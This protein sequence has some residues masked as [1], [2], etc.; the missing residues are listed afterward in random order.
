MFR[1]LT[2]TISITRSWSFEKLAN[3]FNINGTFINKAYIYS[4]DTYLNFTRTFFGLTQHQ[5]FTDRIHFDNYNH[6][7]TIYYQNPNT[8]KLERLPIMDENGMPDYYIYGANWV[9]WTFRVNGRNID[10]TRLKNGL[11]RYTAF[12]MGKNDIDFNSNS[13]FIFK[14]KKIDTPKGWEKDFLTK[15]VEKPWIDA[16]AVNWDEGEFKSD[17][18]IIEK[19]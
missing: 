17:I 14:V 19:I 3:H 8:K 12:Y 7:I 9:N 4:T 15:Q 13:K 1:T 18:K 2:Q 5:V 6:T 10:Q 11:K 16:G